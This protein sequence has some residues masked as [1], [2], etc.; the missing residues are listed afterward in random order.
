M[1]HAVVD[2]RLDGCCEEDEDTGGV[3]K[4]WIVDDV[5]ENSVCSITEAVF[6]VCMA[7]YLLYL[8]YVY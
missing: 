7:N 6:G 4:G 5:L 2:G 8:R 3:C 1:R